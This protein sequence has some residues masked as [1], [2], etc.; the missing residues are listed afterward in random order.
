MFGVGDRVQSVLK[1]LADERRAKRRR[2]GL[3]W[4][5]AEPLIAALEAAGIDTADF[6]VFG[7]A[8]FTTFDFARAVPVLIEW[9]PRVADPRVKD[10]MARS[11]TGQPGARGEGARR[12]IKEFGRPEYADEVS[13][14]WAIGNALATLAGPADADAVIEILRDRRSGS[15][16]QMFCDALVRTRD[17]RRVDVLIDLIADDDVA[18]HAI[19]A[20]RRISRR[21]FAE[22]ERVRRQLEATL[23]RSSATEF[24]HRQARAALK[25]MASVG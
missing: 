19:S 3:G 14:R 13:L 9:L 21:G 16:R 8:S 12:L 2:E 11:L 1:N 25:A 10:A 18:G 24:A 6:G 17:P 5:E 15:A 7:S 23:R 20:L 4:G 22:P